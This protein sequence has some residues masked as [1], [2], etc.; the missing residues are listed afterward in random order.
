[1]IMVSPPLSWSSGY[2]PDNSSIVIHRLH[3][4]VQVALT[5]LAVWART[6]SGIFYL[7]LSLSQI[8]ITCRDR[9]I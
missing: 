4:L 6:V 2:P 9:M 7:L 3:P 1:M 5:T 8:C